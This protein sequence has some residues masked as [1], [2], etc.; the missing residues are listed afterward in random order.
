VAAA[1]AAGVCCW[2]F[3]G[4]LL[5]LVKW[6]RSAIDVQAVLCNSWYVS[7]QLLKLCAN[8]SSVQECMGQT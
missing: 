4:I 2:R 8:I 6:A 1:A 5:L 3:W 7:A